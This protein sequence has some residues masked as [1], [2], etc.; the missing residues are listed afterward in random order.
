MSMDKLEKA[1]L[2]YVNEIF[3]QILRHWGA[4]MSIFIVP[5]RRLGCWRET[6]L[7]WTS[8]TEFWGKF[9]AMRWFETRRQHKQSGSVHPRTSDHFCGRRCENFGQI[10]KLATQNGRSERNDCCRGTKHNDWTYIP[11]WVDRRYQMARIFPEETHWRRKIRLD[12]CPNRWKCKV[13]QFEQRTC[14]ETK[15]GVDRDNLLLC[16]F[17]ETSRLIKNEIID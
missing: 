7:F 2:L 15:M 9:A 10:R 13:T 12:P 11:S 5:G 1:K 3:P 6:Q 4:K 16:I 14:D 8:I 17:T